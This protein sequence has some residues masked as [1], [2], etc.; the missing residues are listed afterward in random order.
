MTGRLSGLQ[1]GALKAYLLASE[2]GAS[3]AMVN[4]AS[5]YLLQEKL[6][7]TELFWKKAAELN[8]LLGRSNLAWFYLAKLKRNNREALKLS[9]SVASES[10]DAQ[11]RLMLSMILLWN[12][13]FGPAFEEINNTLWQPVITEEKP[14]YIFLGCIQMLTAKNQIAFALKLFEDEKYTHL[15]LK[16]KLKPL[17]Y[18]ILREAGPA[19]ADDAL[20]MG[21]ELEETVEEIRQEIERM[22]QDY[23]IDPAEIAGDL[24]TD[25][26]ITTNDEARDS[27]E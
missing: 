13:Q 14:W 7:L 5:I 9:K 8:D 21:P 11:S 19:R 12:N 15:N 2:Q 16:E 25:G 22:R 23:R 10:P 20:R 3:N 17:Y 4:L 6:G 1:M 26:E 18:A 27:G 24:P